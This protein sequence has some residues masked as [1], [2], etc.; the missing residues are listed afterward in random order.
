[1]KEIFLRLKALVKHLELLNDFFCRKVP[2]YEMF[3]DKIRKLNIYADILDNV[4]KGA[5]GRQMML[6]DILTYILFSRVFPWVCRARNRSECLKLLLYI[7]NMVLLQEHLTQAKYINLRKEFMEFLEKGMKVEGLETIFFK[8]DSVRRLYEETK[9]MDKDLTYK[10][11]TR[12]HYYMLD[13]L[14]TKPVGLAI[15]FIT[16]A[17][18]LR[19]S[20]GYIIPLA[21]H[22]RIFNF[23]EYI[24]PPNYMVVVEGK[25][26]GIEVKQAKEVPDHIFQFMSKTAI[27]VL[28]ASIPREI[29]LRCYACG[30]WIVF[31][32]K[33]IEE[34]SDLN[35]PISYYRDRKWKLSCIECEHYNNMTCKY[36]V[37]YGLTSIYPSKEYHYHYYCVKDDPI[38]KEK[39]KSRRDQ[40]RR[41][42]MY[43]PHVNGLEVIEE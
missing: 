11:D 30:K 2:E 10:G 18:L 14:M 4:Y 6:A 26:F 9:E 22:Q 35:K 28:I 24:T 5:N 39:L 31:C 40:E 15:E 43:I 42:F 16:Y 13:S 20:K 23:K 36:M 21:L 7:V 38:V 19:F 32:D 41:L 33:A 3:R 25:A 37:Y 1:M 27:P 12:K 29:P 17:H 8:D 34:F